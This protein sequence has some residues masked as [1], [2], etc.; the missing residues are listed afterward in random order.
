MIENGP[1]NMQP[2]TPATTTSVQT[3]SNE[4]KG[5]FLIVKLW[6]TSFFYIYLFMLSLSDLVAKKCG[7]TE[8]NNKPTASTST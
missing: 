6:W 1:T 4:L 7:S 8:A 2:T 3:A 5:Y